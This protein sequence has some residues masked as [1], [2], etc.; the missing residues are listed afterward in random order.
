MTDFSD[1]PMAQLLASAPKEIDSRLSSKSSKKNDS[2]NQQLG[3]GGRQYSQ[4][5]DVSGGSDT[6]DEAIDNEDGTN[7]IIVFDGKSEDEDSQIGLQVR[8]PSFVSLHGQI[9]PKGSDSLADFTPILEEIKPLPM[10]DISDED[11]TKDEDDQQVMFVKELK[12]KNM[13]RWKEMGYEPPSDLIPLV[14]AASQA[15]LNRKLLNE[16]PPLSALA[17]ASQAKFEIRLDVSDEDSHLSPLTEIDEVQQNPE[18]PKPI[19]K[20]EKYSKPTRPRSGSFGMKPGEAQQQK[21]L[22]ND[23]LE[24]DERKEE[25]E[26]VEDIIEEEEDYAGVEEYPLPLRLNEVVDEPVDSPLYVSLYNGGISAEDNTAKLKLKLRHLITVCSNRFWIEETEYIT[27][28]L[29]NI[30]FV[31][32]PSPTP[33]REQTIAE[34]EKASKET[35][36]RFEQTMHELED[37]KEHLMLSEKKG[38]EQRSQELDDKFTD[39]FEL[40]K[41]AKP[42]KALLDIR[43]R[44]QK[45]LQQKRFT[46]AKRLSQEAKRI[47]EEDAQRAEARIQNKYIDTDAKIKQESAQRMSVINSKYEYMRSKASTVYAQDKESI[48]N[49]KNKAYI[50]ETMTLSKQRTKQKL[51]DR[52]ANQDFELDDRDKEEEAHLQWNANKDKS[53]ASTSMSK[54]KNQSHHE[55]EEDSNNTKKP[56][57]T[58]EANVSKFFATGK[59]TIRG[60]KLLNRENDIQIIEH[61]SAQISGGKTKNTSSVQEAFQS[62]LAP[63]RK[64]KSRTGAQNKNNTFM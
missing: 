56:T 47:E 22:M 16:E 57:K 21:D 30:E 5:F 28:V 20:A 45:A 38:Y 10:E 29:N 13:K 19:Q 51:K 63:Q 33:A 42:S 3:L 35:D 59:L 14:R 27:R 64:A 17:S 58:E 46:E 37:A 55:E 2:N 36:E 24:I 52:F 50:K 62:T 32:P 34:L 48:D 44:A 18:S 25:E 6:T 43:V 4:S 11:N 49:A 53:R 26:E 23:I 61:L 1:N 9:I 31:P 8:Q 39:E 60:P 15:M 54:R 7:P 40:S 41:M 12:S